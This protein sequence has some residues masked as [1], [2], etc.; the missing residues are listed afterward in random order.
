MAVAADVL[1]AR[2]RAVRLLRRLADCQDGTGNLRD[3]LTG[4]PLAPSHYAVSLFA[5]A[6][7]MSG[8]EDL[9]EPAERAVRYF[10]GLPARVRG[11]PELNNLGLLAVYRVWARTL[12]DELRGRLT[13]YFLR[14]PFASLTGRA[15]NN[16]H[17]M[18]AVCLVQRGLALGRAADV[19]A[20][21]RCMYH[22]V[23]PL[24]DGSGLFADYPARG[25]TGDRCTP[26]TYHA[27][28]CAMLAMVLSDLPDS[29]IQEALGRGVVALAQ[30]CAPDGET[31]YFGRSCNSLYGYAAA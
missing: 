26:L 18:R 17:A 8:E 25:S 23:L 6:C 14:M 13:S 27:K 11:A 29:Q 7:A 20:A 24:Q 15:T 19:E 16:W 2:T 9:R 31:L 1:E 10:L 28:F 21:R 22:E 4:Q 30:L 12:P 3:P 5:G